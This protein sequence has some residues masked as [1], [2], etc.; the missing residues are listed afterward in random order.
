MF[1]VFARPGRLLALALVAL[2]AAGCSS[3][4]TADWPPRPTQAAQATIVTVA[5]PPWGNGPNWPGAQAG[6]PGFTQ[7]LTAGATLASV[8]L[9]ALGSGFPGRTLPTAPTAPDLGAIPA[10][11]LPPAVVRRTPRLQCV[12]FARDASGIEI[13]GNANTWWRQAEGRYRRSSQP[14][15]GAVIAMRGYRTDRRGHVAVVTAMKSEREI[16]VDHANW[17]NRG[18]ISVRTPVLD[19]SEAGDWSRVRVWHIP[20]GR[21]GARIYSVHGFIHQG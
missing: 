6:R 9:P 1:T 16:L 2:S 19:V 4:P 10:A 15:I 20:S 14:E 3:L 5:T 11:S 18:E 17:L 12:P 8:T 7:P 13:Y 21:W